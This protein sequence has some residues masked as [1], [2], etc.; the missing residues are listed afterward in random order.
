MARDDDPDDIPSIVA[1]RDD[2]E[3]PR[4]PAGGVRAGAT[5]RGAAPAEAGSSLLLRLATTLALVVAAVACAW[6]WQLEERL[7]QAGFE[8]E[9]FETRIGDLEARLS[10]TDEGLSQDTAA[11]A[12]KIKELYSEVDKLWA[13]AWRRNKA[14]LDELEGTT[15]N[16]A[17][18]LATLQDSQSDVS[19]KLEATREDVARLKGVAGDLERL[20]GSARAN[21]AQVEEIADALN[22]LELDFA[23]LGKR[24]AANEGWVESIN[25]FRR[26]VNASISEL[27]SRVRAL[28]AGDAAATP[29]Q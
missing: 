20:M 26:Q 1:T 25:A 14:R 19:G 4:E 22:R 24:V 11:M 28:R 12:V 6:A 18:R 29:A 10:D 2:D 21:Q 17:E 7:T 27:E 8:R 16:Q 15:V 5:R 13:S 3:L 23:R 9:R